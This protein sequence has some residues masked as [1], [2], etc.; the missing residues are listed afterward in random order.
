MIFQQFR[1]IFMYYLLNVLAVITAILLIKQLY[2]TQNF[3]ET[4]QMAC[5]VSLITLPVFHNQGK[6]RKRMLLAS[7]VGSFLIPFVIFFHLE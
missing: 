2:G 7:I 4:M 5:L 3:K 6:K 1:S